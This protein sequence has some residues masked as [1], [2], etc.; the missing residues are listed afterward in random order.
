MLHVF[1]NQSIEIDEQKREREKKERGD[2]RCTSH[3]RISNYLEADKAEK[4][5][6]MK[7]CHRYQPADSWVKKAGH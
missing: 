2:E 6:N 1:H 3:D 7:M 5:C 4:A